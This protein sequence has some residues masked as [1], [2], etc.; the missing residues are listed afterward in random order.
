[1][2]IRKFEAGGNNHSQKEATLNVS[3][4]GEAIHV[5]SAS[6]ERYI[7]EFRE[8]VKAELSGIAAIKW[9]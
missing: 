4:K 9:K 3:G 8:D 7:K 5:S 2:D 6:F 1:M